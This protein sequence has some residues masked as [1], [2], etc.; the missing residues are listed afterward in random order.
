[1]NYLGH[2]I[3]SS[4]N[5][6]ITLGNLA[7]D[8]L[9][10]KY[11]H[12]LDKMVLRGVW[13]HRRLDSTTDQNPF[14]KKITQIFRPYFARYSPVITDVFIDFLITRH[15]NQIFELELEDFTE[16]IYSGILAEHQRL[17]N[18]ASENMRRMAVAKWLD[19]FKNDLGIKRVYNS[20]S[21]KAS[22][23]FDGQLVL[24]VYRNNRMEMDSLFFSFI[25][26]NKVLIERDQLFINP[27]IE[28][29]N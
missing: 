7:G 3:F 13:L 11:H 29:K 28:W 4:E 27:R 22:R 6:A 21:K 2:A 25:F 18:H 10:N 26:H 1:M 9:K 16:A 5:D 12:Q 17:P 24:E 8:M 19:S 23:S 14:F 15:W 20:L